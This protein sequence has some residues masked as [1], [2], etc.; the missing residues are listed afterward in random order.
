MS[1]GR[2]GYE[3]GWCRTLDSIMCCS[4]RYRLAPVLYQ[5]LVHKSVLRFRGVEGLIVPK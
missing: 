2:F 3:G 1:D 4:H 5:L